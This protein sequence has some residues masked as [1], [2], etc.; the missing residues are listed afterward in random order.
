[1]DIKE[2]KYISY[3]SYPQSRVTEP[4]LITLL[5]EASRG[6]NETGY[7]T[8]DSQWYQYQIV[9]LYGEKYMG[10]LFDEPRNECQTK[11][12]YFAGTPYWF[13]YEPI[14]WRV[15][16]AETGLVMS[17]RILDCGDFH[18]S[19]AVGKQILD[20]EA[21]YASN[22]L[23]SSVRDWLNQVFIYVA[24]TPEE[25]AA[26]AET[27]LENKSLLSAEYNCDDCEDKIFLLSC[28]D[29]ID[30]S[31]GFCDKAD[32]PDPARCAQGTDFAKCM[33]LAV[34]LWNNSWWWLRS[35]AT[36][37][38]AGIIAHSGWFD[39]NSHQ[40]VFRNSIGIRP[41]F[42]IPDYFTGKLKS[43]HNADDKPDD[44][45][46]SFY[47]DDGF[48]YDD[49]DWLYDDDDPL[50][51]DDDLPDD[52]CEEKYEYTQDLDEKSE[53]QRIGKLLQDILDKKI[54]LED[55]NLADL[56]LIRKLLENND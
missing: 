45:S 7:P 29:L 39:H 15:L 41:A 50:D 27:V 48:S 13:K 17:E 47:D 19:H 18:Q 24:F 12:G 52:K 35:P 11:N 6:W 22:Y 32:M 55:L 42:R 33:G 36:K 51:N 20:G 26:I 1:M 2:F 25:M 21:V 34:V 14:I 5:N 40:L 16:D 53:E 54:K 43:D 4:G 56:V 30:N 49:F 28:R 10:V 23:Y 8:S 44:D 3:G 46:H 31:F 9:S 38:S 37:R